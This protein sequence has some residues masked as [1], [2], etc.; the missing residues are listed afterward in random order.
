MHAV[1]ST[2]P[3]NSTTTVDRAVIV[4]NGATGEI[5]FSRDPAHQV[6][7]VLRGMHETYFIMGAGDRAVE[8]LLQTLLDIV[9][10][11][12]NIESTQKGLIHFTPQNGDLCRDETVIAEELSSL[13]QCDS[14]ISSSSYLKAFVIHDGSIVIGHDSNLKLNSNLLIFL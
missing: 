8:R 13:A 12:G 4:A 2:R 1:K 9:L 5:A 7:V 11:G 14:A 3:L 6:A 10:W